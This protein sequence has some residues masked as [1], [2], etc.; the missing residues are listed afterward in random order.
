MSRFFLSANL[1]RCIP[2]QIRMASDQLGEPGKGAGKGGGGGGSVKEAGGALGKRAVT[3]EERYFRQRQKENI[4]A[5][6]KYHAEEIQHHKAEIM[7]QQQVMERHQGKIRKL[8][9]E[10]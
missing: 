10:D 3:E 9:H 2:S 1:R 8:Q 7:H 5:M 4:E 6:A